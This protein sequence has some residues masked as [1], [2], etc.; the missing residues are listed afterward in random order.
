MTKDLIYLIEKIIESDEFWQVNYYIRSMKKAPHGGVIRVYSP[1]LYLKHYPFEPWT[2]V[3]KSS[4]EIPYFMQNLIN[5]ASALYTS[6]DQLDFE[7]L[8]QYC[9]S[10]DNWYTG[11]RLLNI[12]EE[13]KEL[14]NR[15]YG[16]PLWWILQNN[17]RISDYYCI[18][19]KYAI[20]A[21][22]LA[23]LKDK[24]IEI[25][26]LDTVKKHEQLQ[27]PYNKY[28]LTRTDNIE[29]R[30]QG[31]IFNNQYYLYNIFIDPTIGAPHAPMP[32]T[33]QIIN[34]EIVDKQL[35]MRCD[36]NIAVPMD[37]I[38]STATVDHQKYQ[39][40][41]LN[42]ANIEK[43]LHKEIIVHIH[44]E[45][46]HKILVI[47]K[48]DTEKDGTSFYHIEVE[49][50]WAPDSIS[51]S[52]IMA[53]FIHSKF[54]PEEKCFTHIDFSVN[55]YEADTYIAKYHG[56]VNQT[57]IP[58]DKYGDVHYKVWCVEAPKIT[59]D[60]WSKLISATLDDPFRAI[61]YETF[62]S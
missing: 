14:Y 32:L 44:P 33:F 3:S 23:L 61:F 29:F 8:L 41:T 36:N 11:F 46:L 6:C 18:E 15:Y 39:G 21:L 53:T 52:K 5:E 62:K 17:K 19:P 4:T 2:F 27:A 50:L 38:F 24:A 1:N 45:L 10:V 51:D 49:E 34:D 26:D 20:Y 55:Q 56:A 16:C 54:Y 12:K 40:I 9:F 30:R 47:I 28:G 22:V 58:I 60:T 48:P 37:K 35:Y 7:E 42:F 59:I 43:L 57:K 13:H 31:F 25:E